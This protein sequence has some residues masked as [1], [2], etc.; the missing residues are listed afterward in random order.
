MNIVS[1]LRVL[2]YR[3]LCR[4]L[5]IFQDTEIGKNA[6]FRT[7]NKGMITSQKG[8]RMRANTNLV[9]AGGRINLGQCVFFNRNCNVVARERITI[10]NGVS[11]GPN[12]C[13]FDH[14]HQFDKKGVAGTKYKCGEVVIGDG[15]WIGAG[16]IILRDTHIGE[17]C[18]IGA[19]TI[20]RGNIPPHSIVTMDRELIIREINK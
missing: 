20:V 2:K 5:S 19:G 12:V 10:G 18:V 16:A 11:C 6:S 15:C 8:L 14:D 1:V 9:S 4:G 17:G 3:I 7:L 13:I